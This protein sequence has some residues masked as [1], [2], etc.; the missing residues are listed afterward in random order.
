MHARLGL[1]RTLSQIVVFAPLKYR[2][3]AC[4]DVYSA[5]PNKENEKPHR[6][7]TIQTKSLPP[8]GGVKFVE[9]SFV[10]EK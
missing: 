9:I 8:G 2:R 10:A 6:P 7:T 3:R 1:S 5:Y 4:F